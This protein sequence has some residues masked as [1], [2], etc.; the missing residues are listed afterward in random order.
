MWDFFVGFV[1]LVLGYC[2]LEHTISFGWL[3]WRW[4]RGTMEYDDDTVSLSGDL[5]FIMRVCSV[6]N[7][8]SL[9]F[10]MYMND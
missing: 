7:S 5:W 9:K 8:V 3:L 6:V 2:C 10:I 4:D 1:E